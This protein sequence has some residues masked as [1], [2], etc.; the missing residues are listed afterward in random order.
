MLCSP[1][2]RRKN[3]KW[4]V[5][6]LLILNTVFANEVVINE[7]ELKKKLDRSV[8]ICNKIVRGKDAYCASIQQFE[9]NGRVGLRT[10]N[11]FNEVFYGER[12]FK[13]TISHTELK[14]I[15]SANIDSQILKVKLFGKNLT[16]KKVASMKRTLTILYREISS[17]DATSIYIRTN[18]ADAY[19]FVGYEFLMIDKH[20]K[21]A[22]YIT[23]KDKYHF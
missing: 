17:I 21:D 5:S 22:F 8:R 10:V 3:M 19:S 7:V 18:E 23:I 9:I 6:L 16:D 1:Y 20:S 11:D 15:L 4:M 12:P 2:K 14:E 13:S